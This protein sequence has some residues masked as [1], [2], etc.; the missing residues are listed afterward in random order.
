MSNG[1]NAVR[2]SSGVEALIQRLRDEGVESGRAQAEKIVAD[3]ETRAGWILKQAEEDAGR[4]RKQAREEAERLERSGR[5]ALNAA[6]RDALLTSLPYPGE[7]FKA[8]QTP[9]SRLKLDGRLRMLSEEDAALLGEVEGLVHW[10]NQPM[11]RTDAAFVARAGR[12]IPSMEDA[13]LKE[14][15]QFRLEVRTAIAALRRRKRGEGPPRPDETWGYGRWVG[16]I[17]RYWG[18]P[19]FRLE[20]VFPWLPEASQ[21]L[22][23]GDSLGLERLLLGMAWE[24]LGRAAEQH[25][26]DLEAVVLYVQRWDIIDRWT[27]YS[28]EAAVQRFHALVDKGL[29]EFAQIFS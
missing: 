23:T 20:G 21:L 13:P 2:V 16:H 7:L 22:N 3:A 29:G 4:L 9:L 25:Y 19:A 10:I 14:V 17:Q 15:V 24:H 12:L 26:F 28:G 11:E 8:K 1:E 27:T 18:E 5:E 6:A